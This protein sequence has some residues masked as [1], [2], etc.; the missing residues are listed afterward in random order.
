M[1]DKRGRA[2]VTQLNVQSF[3][4]VFKSKQKSEFVK[5]SEVIERDGESEREKSGLQ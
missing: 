5:F 3:Q 1:C 2:S 4:K